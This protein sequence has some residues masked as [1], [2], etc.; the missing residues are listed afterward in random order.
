LKLLLQNPEGLLDIV[1]ANKNFQS[2]LLSRCNGFTKFLPAARDAG[3]ASGSP[4]WPPA[5]SPSSPRFG[6]RGFKLLDRGIAQLRTGARARNLVTSTGMFGT[7]MFG[8]LIAKL[9]V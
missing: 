8:E 2:E 4:G 5:C 9:G 1:V 3:I 6:Q 7:G